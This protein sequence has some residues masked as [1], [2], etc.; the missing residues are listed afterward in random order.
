MPLIGRQTTEEVLRALRAVLKWQLP[1]A[2]WEDTG[3]LLVELAD[4]VRAGDADTVEE[5]TAELETG[6]KRVTRIKPG[7]EPP[8][9]PSV[10][11]PPV[12][13]ER[14]VALIHVLHPDADAG[15]GPPEDGSAGTRPGAK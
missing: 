8:D 2:A 5:V 9:D 13:R 7:A 4:A 14:I 10:P 15:D 6:G 11:V 1:P 12:Q 3:L